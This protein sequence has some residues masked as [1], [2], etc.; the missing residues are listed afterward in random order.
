MSALRLQISPRLAQRQ[1][2]S[3]EQQL[4]FKMLQMSQHEL[5]SYLLEEAQTNPFLMLDVTYTTRSFQGGVDFSVR[6]F[7]DA[8]DVIGNIPDKSRSVYQDLFRQIEL[9]GW[10]PTL[11][12]ELVELVP[13]ID[14]HGFLPEICPIEGWIQEEY[15]DIVMQFQRL[16]PAGVG[17]RGVVESLLLQAAAADLPTIVDELIEHHLENIARGEVES[18]IR[19]TKSDADT[20]REAIG[21][22]RSLSPYALSFDAYDTVGYQAPD[23][24]VEVRNDC[25]EVV[26]S[27]S[28][29]LRPEVR[30]E[31]FKQDSLHELDSE[32]KKQLTAQRRQAQS[33]LKYC[34]MREDTIVKVSKILVREQESFLRFGPAHLKP[35]SLRDV[36]VEI[37]VHESTISRATSGKSM[38][39][40]RGLIPMRNFFVQKVSDNDGE[41]LVGDA[42]REE[43]KAIMVLEQRDHQANP[44][45]DQCLSE[46]LADK[47]MSI[48]R[49]TVAK[50][51]GILEIPSK[52]ERKRAY[53][54]ASFTSST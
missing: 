9:S 12:E 44:F 15:E 37:G 47:G 46:M 26:G 38:L 4:G 6:S 42:I 25:Y 53:K 29:P 31:T 51:R 17:A 24:V 36:A 48:A 45:S 50:Y 41:D 20:I 23:V 10:P 52:S 21:M 32:Q 13:W 27:V 22:L 18:V 14:S 16:E 35:L 11:R 8:P 34:D 7:E 33:L 5:E 28:T 39:T 3:L 54:L 49:R 40:D 30:D 1:Q 2:L 43:M 19:K